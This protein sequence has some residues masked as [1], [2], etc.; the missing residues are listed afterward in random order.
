MEAKF[1]GK[2][3][4]RVSTQKLC[5]KVTEVVPH[6]DSWIWSCVW[7][8]SREIWLWRLQE[9][10]ES[11]LGLT[12]WEARKKPLVGYSFSSHW[13]SG[14]KGLC[15]ELGPGTVKRTQEELLANGKPVCITTSKDIEGS[16]SM[17]QPPRTKAAKW[18]RP[19]TMR[20]VLW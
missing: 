7:E 11:N 9:A 14:S 18:S 16:D 5:S 4:L 3:F 20:Q 17:G 13:A 19:E 8:S 12:L 10:M 15:R 6:V 2:C 1:S